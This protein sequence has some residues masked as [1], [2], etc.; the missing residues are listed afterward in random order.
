MNSLLNIKNMVINKIIS[1]AG[2]TIAAQIIQLL[3]FHQQK[4]LH[5][6]ISKKSRTFVNIFINYFISLTRLILN[7]EFLAPELFSNSLILGYKLS[8][9]VI[10]HYQIIKNIQVLFQVLFTPH[11]QLVGLAPFPANIFPNEAAPNVPNN[12]PRN[13]TFCFLA[14]FLIVLLTRFIIKPQSLQEL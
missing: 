7:S 11:P 4:F 1:P 10:M 14:S 2:A 9:V 5:F 12:T 6:H 13:S 8:S 3:Y